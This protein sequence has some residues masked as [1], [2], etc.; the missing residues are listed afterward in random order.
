[1][2]KQIK[3][4]ILSLTAM[5]IFAS[6]SFITR[7]VEPEDFSTK[8]VI[9][10]IAPMVTVLPIEHVEDTKD[11]KMFS[12]EEVEAIV[13]TLVGECYD[14]KLEDKKKVV[15]VIL[16]RV[17]NEK[18]EKT[19]LEVVSAK[20]QFCGYWNQS[21]PVSESDI[22]IA[23]EILDKWYANDCKALSDYLFFRAGPN[24]ENVFRVKY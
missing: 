17:S 22:Q 7:D 2:N 6:Y 23:E 4:I 19:V 18:F 14:D 9:S 11:V 20:G 15:E 21:R 16:N 8:E 1:M 5:F 12:D 13:R 24:R 3:V 10:T